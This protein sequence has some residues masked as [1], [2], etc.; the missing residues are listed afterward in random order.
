MSEA[1]CDGTGQLGAMLRLAESSESSDLEP[2]A[3]NL[4]SLPGL[5]A[6]SLNLAQTQALQWA[7]NIGQEKPN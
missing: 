5:T 4:A 1:L 7:N 2:L 6:K 3:E